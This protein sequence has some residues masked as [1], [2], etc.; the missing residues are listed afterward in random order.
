M[1]LEAIGAAI[2]AVGLLPD[3]VAAPLP[4]GLFVYGVG[5]GFASSQLA[6]VILAEIPPHASGQASGMQSTFRQ[7]GAAAG[8]AALGLVFITAMT[9]Y[10]TDGLAAIDGL[11]DPQRERIVGSLVD[12]AGWYLYALRAW[13][14][15]FVVVVEAVE[16]AI[17]DAA[18]L[19]AFAASAIFVAG[20]FVSRLLPDVLRSEPERIVVS[21]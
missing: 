7:V 3:R 15:D 19:T 2:V 6:S 9:V 14:P 8:I 13:T 18:R 20:T 17:T 1:A 11:V 4:L 16:H 21:D 12:S 5:I 10:A